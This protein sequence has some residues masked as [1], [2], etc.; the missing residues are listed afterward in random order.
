[1]DE[2]AL[3]ALQPDGG[4]PRFVRTLVGLDREAAK[5]AFTEFLG[6]RT[7]NAD[8]LEFVDLII[9]RLAA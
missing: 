7:L 5:R 2:T 3:E 8:Q 9:D 4:L 1:V 6:G